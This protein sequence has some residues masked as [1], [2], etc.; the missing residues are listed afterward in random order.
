[1]ACQ[2]RHVIDISSALPPPPPPPHNIN[3]NHSHHT[4]H[5][6]TTTTTS[7]AVWAQAVFHLSLPFLSNFSENQSGRHVAAW[8]TRDGAAKR[9]RERRLRSW[10]KHERQTVRMVLAE[11]LHHSSEHFPPMFKEE[12][13]GRH[14]QHDAYGDRRRQG[15]RRPRTSL[16]ARRW[17]GGR[18][19]SA[20]KKSPAGGRPAP[21]PEVAGRQV[22]LERHVME[23]LGS[24]CPFVQILDL[25]VPQTVDYVADA[26]R[27]QDLPMAEQVIEVPKISCSPVL[28]L[29]RSQRNSW[30]KCRPY[31]LLCGSRS[32]SSAFQFL[33]VVVKVLSQDRGQQQCILLA[34]AFLSGSWSSSS[35]S[36]RI[37]DTFPGDGLGLGSTSSAGAADE[38]FTGVVSTFHHGKKCGVP[39]RW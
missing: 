34:N 29:S 19:S 18:S 36:Q 5:H 32:R 7:V 22:C 27:I 12:L 11:T 1:M 21:L 10:L 39:G 16:R 9:W 6:H 38:E 14:V 8:R 33:V 24:V 28:L 2:Q 15:P 4:P 37:V 26:L 30:W 17:P 23:D 20:L 31:C 25:L 13:V 35:I 3:S